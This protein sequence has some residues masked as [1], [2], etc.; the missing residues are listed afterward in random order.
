MDQT[1]LNK[2][3]LLLMLYEMLKKWHNMASAI[4][5]APWG[6]HLNISNMTWLHLWAQSLSFHHMP[7][8]PPPKAENALKNVNSHSQRANMH[9][10]ILLHT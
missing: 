6:I 8:P 9:L 10:H 7:H 5:E 2:S 4:T 1:G 3:V